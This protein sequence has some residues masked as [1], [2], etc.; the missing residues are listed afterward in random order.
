MNNYI[1][2]VWYIRILI[3]L[4]SEFPFRLF[5]L[6]EHYE[7]GNG[8]VNPLET[9]LSSCVRIYILYGCIAHMNSS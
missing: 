6:S 1:Y 5:A 2:N 8:V 4:V 9:S 3:T 7:L